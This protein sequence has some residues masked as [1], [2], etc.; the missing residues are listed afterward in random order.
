[1]PRPKKVSEIT[2]SEQGNQKIFLTLQA[3]GH[4]EKKILVNL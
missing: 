2:R 3:K 4:S 1:M